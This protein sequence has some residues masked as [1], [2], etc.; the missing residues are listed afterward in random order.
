[1]GDLVA[2]LLAF[3]QIAQT[4]ALDGA[5]MNENVRAAVIRLD[6]AEA[7]LTIKP[8]HGSGSHV[9]SPNM[10]QEKAR[11]R[12]VD[13]RC[14]ERSSAALFPKQVQ[15]VRPKIDERKIA[16]CGADC[17]AK[18]VVRRCRGGNVPPSERKPDPSSPARPAPRPCLEKF[19]PLGR[20]HRQGLR[21]A[22]RRGLTRSKT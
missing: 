8:F 11:I 22:R 16:T 7:L 3:A 21:R 2:H 1:L 6:E 4:G 14:L 15:V 9:V 5:D 18:T 12:R 13:D 17:N 20:G 19:L 10:L